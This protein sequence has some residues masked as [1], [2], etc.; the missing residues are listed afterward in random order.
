MLVQA[1]SNNFVPYSYFGLVLSDCRKLLN[2]IGSY[3]VHFT[4]RSHNHLAHEL[5]KAVCLVV[6]FSL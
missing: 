6:I 1:L 2:S 3:S 5:A 4:N